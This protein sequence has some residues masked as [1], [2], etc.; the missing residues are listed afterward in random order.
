[1]KSPTKTDRQKIGLSRRFA[2]LFILLFVFL[3][4]AG[5]SFVYTAVQ[6]RY[7]QSFTRTNAAQ[8]LLSQQMAATSLEA[9][10][11]NATAFKRLAAERERFDALMQSYNMDGKGDG[12]ALPDAL[13]SQYSRLADIWTGYRGRLGQIVQG[14]KSV[15]D[16]TRYVADVD[17][18]VPKL[19]AYSDQV[20]SALVKHGA[21]ASEVYLAE[22]QTL[23]ALRI[24]VSLTRVLQGGEGASTAADQFGRDATLFGNVL[25]GLLTG[26]TEMQIKPVKDAQT[27]E[28]LRQVAMIF[29]S[30]SDHVA[31]ILELAPHLFAIKHAAT[32]VQTDA[33]Q[34]LGATK[35]LEAALAAHYSDLG[36]INLAGYA[37]GGLAL[38]ILILSGVLLYRDSQHRLALT[39]EQNRRNQRAILRLL[40]EMTNLAE[41]DLTVHATVTEDI[42]GAIADSVNY[43]IDA[44]RSLVTT[45]NQTSVQVATAAERTQTTALRLADASGHQ[46]REIASASAAVTDMADS[47]DR[48]S[49]NAMSS[50]DVAKKSVEIAAKGAAT[51]RR[52]IDGMDTIREQIQDTAKRIKRLGESSQEI[53]DI[54]GLINDIADQTNILA[55]N[56]AI[57][58]SAAGEAGRGFAVVAD[59]VQRLAE[60]S[61]NA[62]RQIEALVKAIQADT[63]EAVL[64]MEQS[65]SNVVAGGQLATDAG[66]A[67][68]EIESVSNQLAKQIMTI[69]SA[70]RQQAAVAANVTNTMNVIQEITMQTSDG[71]QETAQSIGQLTELAAELRRT[72][73]GFKLPDSEDTDTVVLDDGGVSDIEAA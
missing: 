64:S 53:G 11:G 26:N 38:L 50:A 15:A 6:E 28:V 49:K 17:Q 54:V 66:D 73:A 42:T 41:G 31:T 21:S 45:I 33:P 62:T 72:V 18:F 20:T 10:G 2:L 35:V 22:R 12:P 65:T 1:M 34:L 16:I 14:Q 32:Q 25:Q 7:Y 67:L 40:D 58:A 37:S 63:G 57:Q 68:A 9:S 60:R 5:T 69:A 39:T 55:L 43:A 71:T 52:S 27:R 8:Q 46:A 59:E 48:V 3:L 19:L 30:V 51:V 44:L 4:L 13:K 56:A 23:L 24:Q 61:A 29:S 70:A 47:I 36:M